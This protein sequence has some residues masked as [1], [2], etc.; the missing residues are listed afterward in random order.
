[1]ENQGLVVFMKYENLRFQQKFD[2]GNERK[3]VLSEDW[4]LTQ[5][6]SNQSTRVEDAL[7]Y[8]GLL[9]C[10]KM[11]SVF[12]NLG[13]SESKKHGNWSVLYD[14]KNLITSV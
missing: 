9:E 5:I 6:Y 2:D 3:V 10:H 12:Q 1:V 14:G 13:T 7:E 8:I 11:K 4:L